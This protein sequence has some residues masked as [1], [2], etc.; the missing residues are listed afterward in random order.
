MLPIILAT[1][2]QRGASGECLCRKG[3][4]LVWWDAGVLWE[5]VSEVALARKSDPVS[6]ARNTIDKS[7][8]VC[9]FPSEFSEWGKFGPYVGAE[10]A[11]QSWQHLS[12]IHSHRPSSANQISVLSFLLT[13]GIHSSVSP[14][15]SQS[16]SV[17]P[18]AWSQIS[19]IYQ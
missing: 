16:V 9:S 8:E 19:P 17:S 5:T 13:N 6:S 2:T 1:I 11:C 12:I 7:A 4:L 15:Q 18:V 3:G 14:V 10:Q